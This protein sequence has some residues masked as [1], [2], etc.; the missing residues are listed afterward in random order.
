MSATITL[1][2]KQIIAMA[3]YYACGAFIILDCIFAYFWGQELSFWFSACSVL[4]VVP[5]L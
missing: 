2:Y 1:I 3:G 5:L 4:I